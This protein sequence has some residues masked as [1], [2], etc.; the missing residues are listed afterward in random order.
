MITLSDAQREERMILDR[1]AKGPLRRNGA[2]LPL[3]Y[4]NSDLRE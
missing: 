2:F 1:R 4:L 3:P